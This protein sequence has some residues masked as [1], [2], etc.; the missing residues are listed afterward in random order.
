[1]KFHPEYVETVLAPIFR[2]FRDEFRDYLLDIHYAHLLMLSR[3]GILSRGEACA[4]A[5]ALGRA[6]S[7]EL[8]SATFDGNDEDY[9]FYLERILE[10][11]CG[12]AL[13]GRLHTARSRNDIDLTLYRL[14]GRRELAAVAREVCSLRA[15]LLHLCERERDTLIPLHT[16]SQAA[17]PSTVA[18]YLLASLEHL[19]R[20]FRR[21][22]RAL[23]N[24]NRCPLGSCAITG[25][26]FPID[27]ELT[28]RLLAFDG[29]A[30]NTYGGIAAAD[31]LLEGVSA[32]V[33][34]LVQIG[35]VAQD[36]LFWSSS[37]LQHVRLEDG[38]VQVSSIMPQ[39]R[40]PVALEHCRAL[41]SRALG[42][43]ST[44][45]QMLHNTPFGDIV[46]AEDPLQPVV[47]GVLRD[48]ASV[49]R[50]LA[51]ALASATFDDVALEAKAGQYW[52]TLTELA[53]T[54][55]MEQGI[56]FREA[57]RICSVLVDRS[58]AGDDLPTAFAR[59]A[60]QVL[61]R[62]L[63]YTP[64][65]LL[66]IL[67]PRNFVAKRRTAGGPAPQ[68]LQAAL[69]ESSRRLQTDQVAL[70]RDLSRWDDYR[71]LLRRAVHSE[72]GEGMVRS[73]GV[74]GQ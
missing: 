8:G 55:V 23:E 33:V 65:R 51:A 35:R 34:L 39:K 37:E 18:H 56:S 44:I 30:G 62:P 25:T 27:R 47:S 15:C 9:F 3:T 38:F 29:P 67:S 19:E 74:P 20:D 11:Q 60:R 54:L 41:A 2:E 32:V 52:T 50:L 26:G 4:L 46:D 70:G 73:S 71:Q 42:G 66:E 53:D 61:G 36:L 59:A 28:A 6:E 7:A 21:L 17:Q 10:E 24:M 22:V 45:I 40:N 43:A 68:P 69:E 16:H 1:M 12:A 72:L 13:A 63:P 48:S 5:A 31:Y 14:R 58:E 64:E 49:L 57:H